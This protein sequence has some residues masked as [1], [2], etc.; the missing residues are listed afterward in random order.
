MYHSIALLLPTRACC[1]Q[2]RPA[3]KLDRDQ[4]DEREIYSPPYLF[5]GARPTITSVQASI[6]YGKAFTITTP[7]ASGIQSVALVRPAR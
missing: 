7:D 1:W 5:K 2:R 3:R 6:D 4:R